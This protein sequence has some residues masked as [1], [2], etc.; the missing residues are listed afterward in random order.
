MRCLYQKLIFITMTLKYKVSTIELRKYDC[1]YANLTIGSVRSPIHACYRHILIRIDPGGTPTYTT[2]E[3]IISNDTTSTTL[4]SHLSASVTLPT[5]TTR[6]PSSLQ[7][8]SLPTI[9][10]PT[11]NL[12]F[13][14]IAT[15]IPRR[16]ILERR[17]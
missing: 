10:H 8:F 4:N 14:T 9:S 1:L 15:I 5:T 3:F 13:W 2:R 7:L 17:D 16:Q 11:N 12:T 6:Y